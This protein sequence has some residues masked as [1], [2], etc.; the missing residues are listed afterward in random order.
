MSQQ[1]EDEA[2]DASEGE[3]IEVSDNSTE[4]E[5]DSEESGSLVEENTLPKDVHSAT[6]RKMAKTKAQARAERAQFPSRLAGP[7]PGSASWHNMRARHAARLQRMRARQARRSWARFRRNYRGSFSDP[8]ASNSDP[9]QY[10]VTASSSLPS[11]G[12]LS[13]S[14]RWRNNDMSRMNRW[15]GGTDSS[16]DSSSGG[17]LRR[18]R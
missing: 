5:D 15:R 3:V 9:R 10:S 12:S 11:A 2:C 17:E 16:D 4:E 6:N 1:S 8:S 7:R 13:D 18:R 14:V